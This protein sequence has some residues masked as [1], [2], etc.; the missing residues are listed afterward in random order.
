VR[1][2]LSRLLQRPAARDGLRL[3]GKLLLL[4]VLIEIPFLILEATLLV[5]AATGG[6]R[7]LPL[8]LGALLVAA[9]Y[10]LIEAGFWLVQRWRGNPGHRWFESERLL[11][12]WIW[13][14]MRWV[15]RRGKT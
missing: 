6:T 1:A 2:W 11:V 13:G 4:Q 5:G 10:L 7:G 3:G 15:T 9:V 12:G 8:W 14:R